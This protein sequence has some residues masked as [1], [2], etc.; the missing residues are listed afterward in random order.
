MSS[1]TNKSLTIQ[2]ISDTGAP[3]PMANVHQVKKDICEIGRRIYDKGFA[4]AN[5]GNISVRISENADDAVEGFPETRR[6]LPD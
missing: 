1:K 2:L 3:K 5:D 6:H 4:A